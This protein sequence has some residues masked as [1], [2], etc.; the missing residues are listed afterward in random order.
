MAKINTIRK[1]GGSR[2][3]A[4]TNIVPSDFNIVNLSVIKT[5]KDA[6]TIKIEKVE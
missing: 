2:V 6:V 4:V 3:L 1:E 5:T